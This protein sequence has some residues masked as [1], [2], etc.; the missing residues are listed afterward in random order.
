M[1]EF[2]GLWDQIMGA[3]FKS[4][5]RKVTCVETGHTFDSV[6]EAGKFCNRLPEN[7]AEGADL[8][9]MVGGG[10]HWKWAQ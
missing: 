3:R 7:V 10:Y 8:G 4:W 2:G 6:I 9:Y 1:G 5:N